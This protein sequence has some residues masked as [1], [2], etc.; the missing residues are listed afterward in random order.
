MLL[1]VITSGCFACL[2]PFRD[3]MDLY[4]RSSL[5]H[6]APPLITASNS[7]VY[8]I[9]GKDATFSLRCVSFSD[10]QAVW[11][12]VTNA[13]F[14]FVPPTEVWQFPVAIDRD[15]VTIYCA[16]DS[17]L[18][19]LRELG[20]SSPVASVV[21]ALPDGFFI[22]SGIAVSQ[23][24][25]VFFTL[26]SMLESDLAAKFSHSTGL[27]LVSA[28]TIIPG[29]LLW[30]FPSQ[31]VPALSI[32]GSLVYFVSTARSSDGAFLI[33]LNASSMKVA[34]FAAA[35]DPATTSLPCVFSDL[36]SASPFVGPD[37]DVFV[38]CWGTFVNQSSSRYVGWLLHFD[39]V[40]EKVKTPGG[41][42]WD[43]IPVIYVED[44]GGSYQLLLKCN[45]YAGIN[46]GLGLNRLVLIDPQTAEPDPKGSGV[47]VMRVVKS[48]LS[49]TMDLSSTGIP[50]ARTE[51]CVNRL[52]IDRRI[53]IANN[54]DSW[55]Y[56]W[57]L[58]SGNLTR[59]VQLSDWSNF[60]AY[61][62]VVLSD[63]DAFVLAINM[64][65]LNVI[66][67]ITTVNSSQVVSSSDFVS[68]AWVLF[69][70]LCGAICAG[71]ILYALHRWKTRA[72][73]TVHGVPMQTHV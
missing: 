22:N 30:T 25:D 64:G 52:G 6:F 46:G 21:A 65:T 32:D 26:R 37:G 62:S 63:N 48:V 47:Q 42:G 1:I 23:S 53:A 19:M 35:V 36:S 2:V 57:D 16:G 45:D 13:S 44:I 73:R 14:L 12:F 9:R 58:V 43:T 60:Q 11:T 70:L 20:S 56:Q 54:E 24:G 51:W 15:G 28:S 33:A 34:H 55:L 5:A 49:P 66:T 72:H 29:S 39:R 41:C 8:T 67:C 38:G 17:S 59:L 68:G 71:F 18:I 3:S 31:M 69:V 50:N 10:F 4:T 7:F 61:T 27:T 40:L